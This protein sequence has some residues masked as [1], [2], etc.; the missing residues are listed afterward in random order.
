MIY[1]IY[2]FT[3]TARNPQCGHC[4]GKNNNIDDNNSSNS[5][6]NNHHNHQAQPQPQPK[7]TTTTAATTT[8]TTTGAIATKATT[9]FRTFVGAR[10][11]ANFLFIS[12]A[13]GEDK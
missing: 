6:N 3:I 4:L 12:S 1:M 8:T 9:T 5:N 11:H 7:P 2:T 13:V 10:R